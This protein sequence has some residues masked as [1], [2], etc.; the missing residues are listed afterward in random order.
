MEEVWKPV[1]GRESEYLVS[2]LGRVK[3]CR[4]LDGNGLW[5]RERMLILSTTEDG[6]K[7]ANFSFRCKAQSRAVHRIVYETF[8][9]PIP[10]GFEINHKNGI[11]D[12][13]RPENLEAL[14]HSDNVKYSKEVLKR[15]YASFGNLRMTDEDRA[16]IV[17]K[18]ADGFTHRQIGNL[19]GFSKSRIGQV[20]H[21]MG[22]S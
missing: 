8:I 4:K 14:T 17:S 22:L 9:G 19:I 7:R 6:Y 1:V 15:N 13:N 18:R 11:R 3:G 21:S 20:L 12:D 10:D 5:R 2:N 16:A